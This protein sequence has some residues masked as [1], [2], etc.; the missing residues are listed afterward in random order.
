MLYMQL[1]RAAFEAQRAKEELLQER[2][3]QYIR[4][5]Q[6]YVAKWRSYPPSMDSLEKA[7]GVR[8]LRKRY[9]DPMTG[10]DE[11]RL[12]HVNAAGQLV[13]SLVQKKDEE[14][15]PNLNNFITEA[16]AI[17]STGPT[18]EGA[19]N[20]AMRRRP[21]DQTPVA[22]AAGVNVPIDPASLGNGAQVAQTTPP[23]QT[24]PSGQPVQPVQPGP[25]PNDP[26]QAPGQQPAQ[27]GQ[28][29]QQ[30]QQVAN[31][32]LP[33][34]V[35]AAP[36]AQGAGP[37]N[38]NPANTVPQPGQPNTP[39]QGLEMINKIL[40]TPRSQMNMA[41][42]GA[43]GLQIGGGIAGVASVFEGPSIKLYNERQKYQEWEFVYDMKKDKRLLGAA[44]A[45]A[46]Q[47]KNNPLGGANNP[48]QPK[49]P[50]PFTNN[51]GSSFNNNSGGSFNNPGGSFNNNPGG[52][53][54]Q[55]PVQ[56]P[57]FPQPGRGR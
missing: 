31:S 37:S 20:A 43:S 21:S 42:P 19:Q 50:S 2:G 39:N 55:Q 6:L 23:G 46:N 51:G 57:G 15:K 41:I 4:A 18:T 28:P 32:G 48:N 3:E 24:D 33:Y 13:D 56:I 54:Q 30:Q 7:N 16:P 25:G 38:P 47:Q 53:Q 34:P 40:T 26:N 5:I 9:K 44:G 17:G 35:P 11:W 29:Q 36:G 12:V 45:M 14:K 10:K 22:G 52:G 1:P 49:V 27:P 8:Y